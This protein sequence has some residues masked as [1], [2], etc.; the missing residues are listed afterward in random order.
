MKSST[1]QDTSSITSVEFADEE[2]EDEVEDGETEVVGGSVV[3]GDVDV[4]EVEVEVEVELWL[5]TAKTPATAIIITITMIIPTVAALLKA[6][7][8]LEKRERVIDFG[9]DPEPFIVIGTLSS[10]I[11]ILWSFPFG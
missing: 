1:G 5:V 2:V 3:T 4:V 10:L 6:N 7:F 11:S 9:L 8:A